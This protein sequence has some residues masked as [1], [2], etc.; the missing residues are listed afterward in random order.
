[1]RVSAA[2]AVLLAAAFG[3]TA[4]EPAGGLVWFGTYTGSPPQ[5]AGIYVARFDP[6]SGTLSEPQL[7]AE[8]TNPSFVALH[9]TRP[10]LYAVSEV[11]D[12]DGRPTG[13]IVALSIDPATG[14]LTRLNHQSS[15]GGGPCAVSV[16][17]SGRAVL[18]ANYGG[19]SAVCL[20]IEKDGRL[21]PAVSG[22]PSGFIQHEGTSVNPARQEAPHGHSID[23]TPDG[24]FAVVCDLGIDKVLIHALDAAQGTIGPHSEAVVA[25]GAGPRHF[26]FHPD[27]RHAY[28]INELDLTV[29]AFDFNA[30]QGTLKPLQTLSTLP[31]DVTDRSGFST[32][33]IAVHPSGKFVYGS[34]RGHDSIAIYAVDQPTGRLTFLG[35]E[36]IRG[37]TP[38][39]FAIDPSGKWLLAA[40]QDSHS[41]TIFA[42]DP[43]SGKLTFTGKSM[44][45]P[46]P[47]CI[48]FR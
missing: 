20:G 34:N 45:V 23:P 5:G 24:R 19:G 15:G 28:C 3:A 29:T 9:P 31:D 39:N 35:V 2:L 10:L 11:A 41:V 42:I 17:P 32:A 25:A 7:A 8:L 4:A 21:R 33:E 46:A 14:K 40:G 16:D 36:P 12:A 27:S 47:V 38:R 6:G 44:A 48:R 13:S 1:M 22:N 26:A 43:E 18:A 37:K 30:Q